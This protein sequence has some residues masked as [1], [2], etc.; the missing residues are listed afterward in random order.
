MENI[1]NIIISVG[2]GGL[3][4]GVGSIIRQKFPN[5][6][7]IGVEPEGAKGLSESIIQKKALSTVNV[8]SIADSLCAPLHLPYSF[9][10]CQN[11]IDEMVVISDHEMKKS[12]KLMFDYY[13][14]ALEP[15]CVAGIA[16]LT[17]ILKNKFISPSDKKN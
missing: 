17:G 15:A 11:V 16:A 2:G 6:K 4:A 8:D 13:K 10:I 12:M 1:D 3:I 7:I 14:L 9:S 5:C